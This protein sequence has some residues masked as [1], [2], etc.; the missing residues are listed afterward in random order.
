MAVTDRSFCHIVGNIAPYKMN[1]KS[2]ISQGLVQ[3]YQEKKV[4]SSQGIFG[5]NASIKIKF[6]KKRV[7]KSAVNN[8]NPSS[9][10]DN[11][12]CLPNYEPNYFG[13][14]E[15]EAN[16]FGDQK[17]EPNYFDEAYMGIGNYD[18]DSSSNHDSS[19]RENNDLTTVSSENEQI[20][21][22]CPNKSVAIGNRPKETFDDEESYNYGVRLEYHF[23]LQKVIDSILDDQNNRKRNIDYETPLFMGSV[24]SKADFCNNFSDL[25]ASN[26]LTAKGQLNLLKFMKEFFPQADIPVIKTNTG[27]FV[28][29]VTDY[30]NNATTHRRSAWSIFL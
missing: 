14:E 19:S 9:S 26:S 30:V 10:I 23:D 20:V 28:A 24:H 5:K 17:Y 4:K 7:E 13:N 21:K 22:I 1:K 11:D 12:N 6:K 27:N 25:A 16:Y 18:V 29:K 2:S 8:F 15:D 3:H